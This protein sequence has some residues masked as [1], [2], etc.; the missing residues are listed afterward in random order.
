MQTK[1]AIDVAIIGSGMGGAAFAWQLLRKTAGLKI[2]CFER[3]GWVDPSQFPT[4]DFDWQS[5][6]L[7]AWSANPNTRLASGGNVYSA[8][9]A[10]EDKGSQLKP[11]MWNAVGGSTINWSAHFP[12][13]HPSDFMVRSLDGVGVDW[14]ITYEELE[15]WY[16]S[17]NRMMGVAG[18]AGDPAYPPG[19]MPEFPPVAL[20]SMG[21]RAAQAFEALGWHH[22]P[23]SAAVLTRSREDRQAC[24]HCGPCSQGCSTR[25]K[26]STDITYWPHAIELGVELRTHSVVTQ[27]ETAAGRATGVVYRDKKGCE[28]RQPADVV[29]LAGNGIGTARLLLGSGIG[30]NSNQDPLGANLMM[31]PVAYVRGFFREALDGP[32]GPV[33]CCLYSHEF[34]ET[35]KAR[36]F[37]RGLQLQITRENSLL[38]Q[39]L[40]TVPAWGKEAQI[41]VSEEFRHSM[42]VMVMTEDLPELHNRVSISRDVACDGLPEVSI[43]YRPAANTDAMLLFGM[44]RAEE[45]LRKAGAYRIVRQPYPPMTGWHLLGTAA[46]GTDPETSVVDPLGRCHRIPNIVVCDGSVFPTAGAVNPASTIG[47]LALRFADRLARDFQ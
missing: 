8:D 40:R 3:G 7:A 35:D 41:M 34:Y 32:V 10:V 28:Y 23:V 36:G 33:G 30:P 5:S 11:L 39:A 45:L 1:K 24:N 27:I 38:L 18:L 20:G 14:P 9:Y 12:R 6:A 19:L 16:E 13:L 2:I 44:D 26:A 31:H 29:V 47:A 37:V 22:W 46:M 43:D 42:V 17:N 15:P 21:V 4:T 25:A